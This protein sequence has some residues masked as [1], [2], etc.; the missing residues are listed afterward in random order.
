[1]FNFSTPN[2]IIAISR[3]LKPLLCMPG[4]T[5]IHM[6]EIASE[7]FFIQ[8]G[9]V[10]V[11]ATDEKTPIAL[12]REG[13][14]FGEIGL[15]LTARRTVTVRATKL[16][17]LQVLSRDDFEELS[18]VFRGEYNYIKK[19]AKQRVK[20]KDPE[21]LKVDQTEKVDIESRR[22]SK[23]TYSVISKLLTQVRRL[24]RSV[25]GV[26]ELFR[27]PRITRVRDKRKLRKD[28]LVPSVIKKYMAEEQKFDSMVLDNEMSLDHP[29]ESSFVIMPLSK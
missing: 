12:L 2:F 18:S 24:S 1:M 14:F 10:Q 17:L 15:I 19:V 11:L 3:K 5:I 23:S 4:D 28:S 26:E 20:I 7:M 25:S 8:R 27:R 6:G 16:T 13:A 22:A 21:D 9:E 29:E